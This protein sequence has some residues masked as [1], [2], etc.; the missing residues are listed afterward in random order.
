MLIKN[1]TKI[2]ILKNSIRTKKRVL[3]ISYVM[4]ILWDEYIYILHIYIH[5]IIM[6]TSRLLNITSPITIM[7]AQWNIISG[8]ILDKLDEIFYVPSHKK[9]HQS[10]SVT[11]IPGRVNGRVN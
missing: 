11:D 5:D 2:E 1:V 3:Q 6:Q 8:V 4:G 7:E 9:F 10:R